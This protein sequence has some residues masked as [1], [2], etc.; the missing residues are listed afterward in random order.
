MLSDI[1]QRNDLEDLSRSFH[2]NYKLY[3][4]TRDRAESNTDVRWHAVK[5]EFIT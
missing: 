5:G 1:L 4:K 2:L 3:G